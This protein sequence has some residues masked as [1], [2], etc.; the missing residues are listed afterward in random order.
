MKL[1][2]KE[3]LHVTLLFLGEISDN[4]IDD[5]IKITK[6]AELG[7]EKYVVKGL[8]A[9]P[10]HFNPRVIWVSLEG[11]INPL[12]SL[13]SWLQRN[14]RAIKVN[15]EDEREFKPHITI[16]RVK[17]RINIKCFLD[18]LNTASSLVFGEFFAREL[19]LYKSTLT[20]EGPVYNEVFRKSI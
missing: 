19:C 4:K 15:Y 3:N 13:R 20:K 10:S 2:E 9:F 18:L 5:L 7:V 16:A 8:G 11:N 1:V 17:E 12:K 6:E 14:L